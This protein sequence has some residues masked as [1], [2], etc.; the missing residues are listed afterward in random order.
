MLMSKPF[1]VKIADL[2]TSESVR[3]LNAWRELG[4][5]RTVDGMIVGTSGHE[6][7]VAEVEILVQDPGLDR[8]LA[9]Y[10]TS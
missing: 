2:V 7:V 6:I 8:S 1:I 5:P 10:N 9:D 3:F 4:Q